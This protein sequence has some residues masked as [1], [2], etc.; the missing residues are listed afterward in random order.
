MKFGINTFLWTVHFDKSNLPLLPKLKEAGFD[1]IEVAIFDP[2]T[3]AAKD[4]RE[5]LAA[6][7]LECTVCS[8]MPAGVSVADEDPRIRRRAAAYIKDCASAIAGAG[9]SL[10]AGPLYT[11]LGQMPGRR[12]THDEWKYAIDTYQELA[13]SLQDTGVTLALEPLNRFETHF[14]NTAADAVRLCDAVNH[15]SVGVL[16]DTFHANIEEKDIADGYRMVGR[17]LKH[18]HTCENDRGAPGSGHVEWDAVFRAL[19]DIE[20]DGWLTIESFGSNIPEIAAAAAI[21]R[22]LAPSPEALA[23]EGLRFLKERWRNATGAVA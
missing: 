2:K 5:G 11:P 3:F 7:G 16:F 19:D 1:G 13:P 21:W 18:V 8:V 12:R 9:A 10:L 23:F 15:D 22:D 17:H 4:L 14:L 6:N 20:Y